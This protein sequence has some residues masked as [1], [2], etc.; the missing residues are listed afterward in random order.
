MFI[1]GTVLYGGNIAERPGFLPVRTEAF[2]KGRG[3]L[4]EPHGGEF[5]PRAEGSTKAGRTRSVV[6]GGKRRPPDCTY[7]GILGTLH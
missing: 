4:S 3:M 5:M 6:D 7:I 1:R 2:P